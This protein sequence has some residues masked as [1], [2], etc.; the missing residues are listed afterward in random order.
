KTVAV[1]A[2]GPSLGAFGIPDPLADPTLE[3]HGSSGALIMQ[4]D[5][6]QDDPSQAAQLTALGLGLPDPHESG[7][8]V[9]L[10]PNF[11]YTAIVAGK[12]NG[13]GVGLV[14]IYDTNQAAASQLA[15]ISTRGLVLTARNVM[16]GGFILGGTA[17]TQVALRGIGPTDRKSVV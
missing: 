10:Q 9:S 5:N 7:L 6:W 8:I 15:N 2:I 12:D 17:S 4:N 14:E 16:I 13:I 1:R 11:S 3:L